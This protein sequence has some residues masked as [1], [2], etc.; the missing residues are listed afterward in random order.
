MH[1][2][3]EVVVKVQRPG[4]S[5]LFDLDFEVLRKLVRFC[6][7]YLPWTRQYDLDAIYQEFA[8]VLY[9][10][11]DYVQEAINADR[12]HHNFRNH[13]RI[14][15]PKVY[16]K[17]TTQKVL[18]MDYVPGIKINDRQ[19]LEACGINVKEINQ[20]GIC[21]YLKQLLQDGFFQADPILATWLSR[22]TA[23]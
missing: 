23:A 2:G 16:P 4:L 21:C 12:F 9:K 5:R 17:F 1:T 8:Q 18:T 13:S 22:K 3:E 7:R 15:V 10:E 20:L 19:S 14:I 6:Q 11:I